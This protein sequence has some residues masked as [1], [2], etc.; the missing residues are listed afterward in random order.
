VGL[1]KA[2][3]SRPDVALIVLGLPGFDGYEV[4]RCIRDALDR[5]VF[6]AALTGFGQADDRQRVLE[7]GFD[8]H[9]LKPVEIKELT[10]LLQDLPLRTALTTG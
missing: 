10:E 2:L 1:E 4:A 6:R 3:A 7:A 9:L 8:A 5:E